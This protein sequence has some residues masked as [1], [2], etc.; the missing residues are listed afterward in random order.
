MAWDTLPAHT[1]SRLAWAAACPLLS[2]GWV[3]A[4]LSQ[5]LA[6]AE[7]LLEGTLYTTRTLQCRR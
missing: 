1:A 6:L 2:V 5:E 7:S 4:L 3:L